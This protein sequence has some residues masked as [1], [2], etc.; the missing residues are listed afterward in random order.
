M[1]GTTSYVTRVAPPVSYICSFKEFF[2]LSP[3]KFQN[4][5]NGI[6][7]RRWLRLCNPGLS[8]LLSE[9]IGEQWMLDLFELKKLKQCLEDKSFLNRVAA[10]KLVRTSHI[11]LSPHTSHLTSSEKQ[12]RALWVFPSTGEQENVCRIPDEAPRSVC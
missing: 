7:P 8:E 6:T 2:E 1:Q 10:V 11:T 4:K 5:T 3:E 9:K 12:I